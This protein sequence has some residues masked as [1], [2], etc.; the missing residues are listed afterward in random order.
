MATWSWRSAGNTLFALPWIGNPASSMSVIA[1]WK[2]W[3]P[4]VW[5]WLS[6]PMIG[7]EL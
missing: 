1:T 7:P 4:I 5:Y 3:P 6:R 2:S